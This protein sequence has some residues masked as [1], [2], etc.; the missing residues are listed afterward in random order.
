MMQRFLDHIELWLSAF[1][2]FVIWAVP[3][4]FAPDET[5]WKVTALTAII[6]GT[7]HGI[8]FWVVRR[9]REKIRADASARIEALNRTLEK[10]VEERTRQVRDLA[11]KLTMAEQKERRRIAQILHD[12]LQQR[13]YGIQ[14]KITFLLQDGAE[15]VAGQEEHSPSKQP[16]RGEQ[17]ERGE[18]TESLDQ[19]LQHA[20]EVYKWID[21]AIKTTRQLS[22]DLSP[23]VLK[24]EGLTDTLLWLTTQMKELHDL[25]IEL[26]AEQAFH[27]PDHDMRVLL[28][29]VVRELLV[30]V[31]KHAD[32]DRATVELHWEE[33]YLVIRVIDE[34]TGFDAEA[35]MARQGQRRGYGLFSVRE[36]LDLFD[37]Q[38]EI[39]SATDGGARITIR[40]PVELM[41]SNEAPPFENASHKERKNVSEAD[42]AIKP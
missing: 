29:N 28:F 20:E 9:R 30:N 33:E 14:M 27:L 2:L 16:K 22:V 3:S 6:V 32:T 31:A 36:R 42:G 7:L 1:G 25:E 41:P 37:G 19:L 8:L 38:M 18:Q 4:L 24:G 5:A 23:P 13:L 11:S 39:D 12:E 21:D 15:L 10:R 40:V 26:K 17:A 35:A 34:G